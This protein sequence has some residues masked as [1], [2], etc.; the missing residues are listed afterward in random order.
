MVLR[1]KH[2]TRMTKDFSAHPPSAWCFNVQWPG[3]SSRT[4]SLSCAPE[5]T[6]FDD[7]MRFTDE[8][9]AQKVKILTVNSIYMPAF[10]TAR[11]QDCLGGSTGF[12]GPGQ[13]WCGLLA[14]DYFSI[15]PIFCDPSRGCKDNEDED[16]KLSALGELRGK[17]ASCDMFLMSWINPSYIW[18]GSYMYER[19]LKE[20]WFVYGGNPT[21]TPPCLATGACEPGIRPEWSIP[22]GSSMGWVYSPEL[23]DTYLSVWAG[24]PS[25][26]FHSPDFVNFLH[27]I[28][29]YNVYTLGIDGLQLDAPE[30]VRSPADCIQ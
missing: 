8:L 3:M 27:E 26:S 23:G 13:P 4:V 29:N 24:Y 17:L 30:R 20:D 14:G 16:S 1:I 22:G 21:I 7:L 28:L 10:K 19:G 11:A 12:T 9:C 6:T 25:A 5:L 15:N 18:T 2:N